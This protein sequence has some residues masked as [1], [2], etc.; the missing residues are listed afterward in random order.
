[1]FR[2]WFQRTT[3]EPLSSLTHF[4]GSLFSIAGLVLLVVFAAQRGTAIQVVS[5]S[6]YGTALILLYVASTLYHIVPMHRKVKEQFKTLDHSMIFVLIAGT[7]TPLCLVVLGGAWGWSLFGVIW[8]LALIGIA[9]K[10]FWKSMPAAVSLSNYIC[11]GWLAVIA[12]LPLYNSLPISGLLWLL[13]GGIAYTVG[14]VFFAF[15]NRRKPAR[16]FG[17]HEWFHVFVMLGSVCHFI[18]M[19]CYAL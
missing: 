11:M 18:V 10:L 3:N 12:F 5:F 13:G 15:E 16:Y 1:M 14:A 7:Y 4:V 17:Y 2:R 6:I 9:L 19:L 8:G